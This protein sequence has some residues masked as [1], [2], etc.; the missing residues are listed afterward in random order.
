VLLRDELVA[1]HVRVRLSEAISEPGLQV[2]V[3]GGS[4]AG[5]DVDGDVEVVDCPQGGALGDAPRVEHLHQVERRV[6]VDL[7]LQAFAEAAN[8][9]SVLVSLDLGQVDPV[10]GE[11]LNVSVGDLTHASRPLLGDHPAE[12]EI[13]LHRCDALSLSAGCDSPAAPRRRGGVR[14]E[15]R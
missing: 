5:H 12:R 13:E 10:L 14:H 8:L 1:V 4:T 3:A 7:A 11:C 6:V 9:G 15:C 2:R